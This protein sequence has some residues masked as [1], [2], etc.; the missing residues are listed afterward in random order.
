MTRGVA[1]GAQAA[2]GLIAAERIAAAVEVNE[3]GRELIDGVHHSP[4]PLRREPDRE[5]AVVLEIAVRDAVRERILHAKLDRVAREVRRIRHVVLEVDAVEV[6]QVEAHALPPGVL[7]VVVL[8][9]VVGHTL[10]RAFEVR[11]ER[12]LKPP[13]RIIAVKRDA[14]ADAFLV[15]RFLPSA[16]DVTLRAEFDGVPRLKFRVPEIEVVVVH[17]LADDVAGAG[18]LVERHQLLRIPLL[19]LPQPQRVLV[20]VLARMAEPFQVIF[21]NAV[22]VVPEL[23]FRYVNPLRIPIAVLTD[24]LRPPMQ[25]HPDFRLAPPCGGLELVAQRF[26]VRLTGAVRDGHGDG[27]HGHLR[28]VGLVGGVQRGQRRQQQSGED[29]ERVFCMQRSILR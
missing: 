18:P 1:I 5:I 24:R 6:L 25:P 21:I 11:E 14:E 10:E 22:V 13:Q 3:I 20:A 7:A 19:R 15:S 9:A 29:C 2:P 4:R 27:L 12:R 26:P 28:V 8:G 23:P 16:E 17:A